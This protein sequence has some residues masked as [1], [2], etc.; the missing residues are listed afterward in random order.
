MTLTVRTEAAQQ[1][2]RVPEGALAAVERIHL[3]AALPDEVDAL[4]LP[5]RSSLHVI[6][7]TYYRPGRR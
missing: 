4:G 1:H 2:T 5:I 7:R 6:E 3:R